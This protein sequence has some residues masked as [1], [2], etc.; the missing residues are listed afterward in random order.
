V[1]FLVA[2]SGPGVTYAEVG[3]FQNKGRLQQHGFNPTQIG[4]MN[5]AFDVVENFVRTQKS[6]DTAAVRRVLQ[7][8]HRQPWAR[9]TSLPT[10]VPTPAEIR[11]QLQWRQLD[12]NPCV[13]WQRVRVPALLVYGSADERFDA[14][15]TVE[16]MKR[17]LGQRPTVTVRVYPDANHELMLSPRAKTGEQESWTW[18]RPAPGFV[19]D[20][21]TWMRQQTR[22]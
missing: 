14:L 13:A 4:K 21:L 12:L 11:S 20:M 15:Q 16:N 2:V 17:T 22:L 9:Y 7:A 8:A 18:P 6:Q 3:R 19:P 10:R 1:A 5:R